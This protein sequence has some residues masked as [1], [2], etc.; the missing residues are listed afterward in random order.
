[1]IDHDAENCIVVLTELVTELAHAT[2]SRRVRS[3]KRKRAL[4]KTRCKTFVD[5]GRA[6]LETV[7]ASVAKRSMLT[8]SMMS[9]PSFGEISVA[10]AEKGYEQG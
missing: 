9:A 6:R 8:R 7:G 2:R 1:V 3:Q 4:A 10:N 5:S